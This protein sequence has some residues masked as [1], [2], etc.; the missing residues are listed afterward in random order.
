M[1]VPHPMF[2]SL[3]GV[4]NAPRMSYIPALHPFPFPS[5]TPSTF[6][7]LHRNGVL[8]GHYNSECP[9]QPRKLFIGGLSHETTDDQVLFHAEELQPNYNSSLRIIFSV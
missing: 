2:M 8:V 3:Q 4:P 9:P 7:P 6:P 1:H 5:F